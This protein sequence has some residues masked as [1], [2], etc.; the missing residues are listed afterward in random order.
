MLKR[1]VST[2]E[3]LWNYFYSQFLR[4]YSL[5]IWTH[6]KNYTSGIKFVIPKN[7][8]KAYR[9]KSFSKIT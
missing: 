2:K 6:S 5:K 3:K 4:T 9:M 8:I 1:S 7:K